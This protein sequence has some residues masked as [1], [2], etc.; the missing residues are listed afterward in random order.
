VCSYDR[1][2]YGWSDSGP[3]P[4]SSLQMRAN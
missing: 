3:E 2:G 1:A 4:R